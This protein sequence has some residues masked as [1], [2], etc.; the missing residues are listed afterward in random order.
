MNQHVVVNHL[1]R[2]CR[3]VHKDHM[4]R[5]RRHKKVTIAIGGSLVQTPAH[6]RSS[7]ARQVFISFFEEICTQINFSNLLRRDFTVFI[8]RLDL[9]N[10]GTTEHENG[11][12]I[13]IVGAAMCTFQ[14]VNQRFRS[15]FSN[16]L[17]ANFT[18]NLGL[19][20][21]SHRRPSRIGKYTEIGLFIFLASSFC[22][23]RPGTT[24][25]FATTTQI[26]RIRKEGRTFAIPNH[27]S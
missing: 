14:G 24:A 21:S 7:R 4:T 23:T 3:I 11:L 2:V 9:H 6:T 8:R 15:D 25:R 16:D 13:R 5:I 26:I 17:F 20:F 10:L 19:V 22:R 12:G 1:L 18:T 27:S